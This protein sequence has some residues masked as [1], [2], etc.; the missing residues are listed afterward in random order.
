MKRALHILIITLSAF[1]MYVLSYAPVVR[2]SNGYRLANS[3]EFPAYEPVDGLIDW[4]ALREPL[5]VWADIWQVRGNF[6]AR[7]S[8][9]AEWR[10]QV[11]QEREFQEAIRAHTSAAPDA[12]Q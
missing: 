10:H 3:R 6:E 5:L 1:V 2:F 8:R 11:H 4:T 7:Y 12:P 9:R